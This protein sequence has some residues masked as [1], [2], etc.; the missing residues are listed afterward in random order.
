MAYN[1][2]QRFSGPPKYFAFYDPGTYQYEKPKI[3][4]NIVPFNSVTPRKSGPDVIFWTDALYDGETPHSIPNISSLKFKQERFPYKAFSE[5]DLKEILCKCG[6][7]IPCE[8]PISEN[9]PVEQEECQAKV[10]RRIFKGICPHSV[11]GDEGLSVPSKNDQGFA[12]LSDGSRR[13]IREETKDDS[14]PFYDARV[15]ESTAFYQGWKWSRRTSKRS[16]KS[17][18]ERPGPADYYLEREPTED[19]ICAEKVRAYKRKTSRQLRFIEMVQR[20]NILEGRPGPASYSPAMPKGTDLQYIGSKAERFPSLKRKVHPGPA[21]HLIRRDFD[22]IPPLDKVCH[23]RLPAPAFFGIKA[24]RF[25]P[26]K[27]EGASPAT[28]HINYKFGKFVHCPTT[29]FGSSAM[30]FKPDIVDESDDEETAIDLPESQYICPTPTWTFKSKTIRMKPLVKMKNEPSP[31]D[32]P[33][34]KYKIERSAHYQYAAPFYSSEPRFEPWHNWS[35]IHGKDQTYEPI[36]CNL[37]KP[38]CP[39][40]V[41]HG[42]LYRAERFPIKKLDS[43]APNTYTIPDE[44]RSILKTHNKRL[45]DN[46]ENQYKFTWKKP[47]EPKSL[48]FAQ[49][50]TLLLQKCIALLEPPDNIVQKTKR[51]S[52]LKLKKL[53]KDKIADIS[54][55]KLD[56]ESDTEDE[57]K[58]P[59]LLRSFLHAY[60]MPIFF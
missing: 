1:L 58:K 54:K 25:I 37:D 9:E 36:F 18:E 27:E 40:A 10:R 45:A 38:K 29:P 31:A 17:L 43:P 56:D 11:L 20:Q 48:N 55:D 57:S 23:A 44:M 47:I 22:P 24:K 42:P 51:L 30:R 12:T 33:Q 26:Q 53:N 50:E 15:Y 16:Q 49:Q 39:P 19:E 60:Q 32:F 13:R 14:P 28:Y 6:V 35:P 59:K 46:I 34:P 52:M 8:C 41:H 4:P 5:E 7:N 2:S 3:K 21:D